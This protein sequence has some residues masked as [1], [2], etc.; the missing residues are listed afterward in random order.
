M[1][2]RGEPRLWSIDWVF[3]FA[4]RE[5]VDNL[6]ERAV[7]IG[8]ATSVIADQWNRAEIYPNTIQSKLPLSEAQREMLQLFHSSA[9]T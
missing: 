2:S 1:T 7:K 8:V 4:G 9:S 3:L 6:R 5:I